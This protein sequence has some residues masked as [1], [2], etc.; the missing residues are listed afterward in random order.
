MYFIILEGESVRTNKFGQPDSGALI[1]SPL[2]GTKDL[3]IKEVLP[4]I[5]ASES[6]DNL[7]ILGFLM[8]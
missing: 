1:P 8:H 4:Y 6:Q 2:L 7:H 5:S 3:D